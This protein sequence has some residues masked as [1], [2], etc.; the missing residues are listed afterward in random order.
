MGTITSMVTAAMRNHLEYPL[1]SS[2]FS[3]PSINTGLPGGGVWR[4]GTI[5]YY[6]NGAGGEAFLPTPSDEFVMG[7]WINFKGVIG[8]VGLFTGWAWDPGP[9]IDLDDWRVCAGVGY[10]TDESE[11]RLYSDHVG[12]WVGSP[13]LTLRASES[14][15]QFGGMLNQRWTWHHM[16]MY[17]KKN[18]EQF[19]C[20][21]YIDGHQ[22]LTYNSG[23]NEIKTMP[24]GW[25]CW[26]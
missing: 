25:N 7:A 20:S 14:S 15:N 13:T 17:F 3:T 16:G 9:P 6:V 19:D 4:N 8:P 24:D 10:Y 12:P 1:H 21:F 2:T 22:F 23:A 18:G 5:S 11:I 26:L